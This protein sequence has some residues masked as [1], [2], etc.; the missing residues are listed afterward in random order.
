MTYQ[1]TSFSFKI[2]FEIYYLWKT[3]LFLSAKWIKGNIPLFLC[4]NVF[5]HRVEDLK[6]PEVMEDLVKVSHDGSMS[7]MMSTMITYSCQLNMSSFPSD[8]HQCPLILAFMGDEWPFVQF[9]SLNLFKSKYYIDNTEF[10]ITDYKVSFLH[11]SSSC[12]H[13]SKCHSTKI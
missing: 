7:W 13:V 8:E 10:N 4:L 9:S 11:N 3:R 12:R 6:S 5:C 2:L 1:K